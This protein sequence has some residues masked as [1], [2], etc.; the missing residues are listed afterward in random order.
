M[1][2]C[3]RCLWT[4]LGVDEDIAAIL[5]REGFAGLDEVAYVPVPMRCW[6]SPSSIRKL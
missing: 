2:P 3:S 4:Q 1:R 6:K 5:V